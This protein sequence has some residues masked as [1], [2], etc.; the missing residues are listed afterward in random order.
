MQNDI[1]RHWA[2][3]TP[4]VPGEML[5]AQARQVESIGMAGIQAWQVW[6]APWPTLSHCAAV[7]E[8]VQLATGLA[9]ALTR[10]PFETALTAIDIDR[11]SGGRFILGFGPSAPARAQGF[12]GSGRRPPARTPA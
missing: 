1:S 12:F 9:N 2:V 6:A 11:L 8:R 10:S 4:Y 5:T 7:T 3:L